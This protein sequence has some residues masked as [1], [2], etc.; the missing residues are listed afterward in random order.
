MCFCPIWWPF[1][2]GIIILYVLVKLKVKW[3]IKASDW[4]KA[5]MK[6]ISCGKEKK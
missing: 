6:E 4:C 3:A 5:K 1:W 2:I